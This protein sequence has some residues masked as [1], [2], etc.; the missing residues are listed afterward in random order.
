MIA[1]VAWMLPLRY[2]AV[3]TVYDGP[4]V[5]GVT[6]VNGMGGLPNVPPSVV[7]GVRGVIVVVMRLCVSTPVALIVGRYAASAIRVCASACRTWSSAMRRSVERA[8]RYVS[9]SCQDPTMRLG[10]GTGPSIGSFTVGG[11][12]IVSRFDAEGAATGRGGPGGP[13]RV[14]CARAVEATKVTSSDGRAWRM[15]LWLAHLSPG[16]HAKAR[17]CGRA[18]QRRRSVA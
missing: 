1:C 7:S 10:G 3:G 6:T 2:V 18:R 8:R 5:A 4:D 11:G 15:A 17:A 13:A 14:A 9:A 12:G 16:M